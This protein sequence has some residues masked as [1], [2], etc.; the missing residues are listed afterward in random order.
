MALVYASRRLARNTSKRR[1]LLGRG[2][3]IQRFRLALIAVSLA[4]AIGKQARAARTFLNLTQ[5]QAAERIGVSTDF[6]AR[7]ERGKALPSLVTFYRM[8]QALQIDANSLLELPPLC[9]IH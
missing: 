9:S 3:V 1:T 7:M 6:Y 8:T 2:L 5:E 4:L